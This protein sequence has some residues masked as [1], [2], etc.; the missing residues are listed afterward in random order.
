M[1]EKYTSAQNIQY[2]F[3]CLFFASLNFE[4]FSPIVEK[5]S[6]AKMTAFLYIGVTILLTPQ[7]IFSTQGIKTS[8]VSIW[9]MFFLMVLSS[10]IHLNINVSVFNT[11]IFLNIIMFW[12]LLN[13][14]RRDERVFQEGVLWFSISS[15]F[16]GFFYLMNIGVT[17]D[18]DMRVAVFGENSNGLGVKMSA[19]AMFLVNYCL[20]HSK[21][22]PICRPWLLVMLFPIVALLLSTASR[23]SVLVLGVGMLLFVLLRPTKKKSVKILWLLVGIVSLFYAYQIV[24]RQEVL[25]A[26]FTRT[27]EEGSIS[28][29]DQIWEVYMRVVERHPILGV[30]FHGG[31]QKSIEAFGQVLSPHNVL[32]EVALYSG[33]FGLSFF[34][35]FLFCVFKNAWLFLKM[36]QSVGPI[37]L[38]VIVVAVVLSGQALGSKLFWTISAY[39]IS[40]GVLPVANANKQ[41]S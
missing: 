6:V 41:L 39:A 31:D 29:R 27:I 25:M 30:G 2:F 18:E 5:L 14:C 23:T 9:T 37:M 24:L 40:Y 28:G 26:R 10:I 8:L 17:I 11:T 38:S 1:S 4:V 34:L 32:I 21:E 22:K 13:H 33:I 12:L 16:V 3:V 15:F 35:V 20:N 7:S 19:G 36:N